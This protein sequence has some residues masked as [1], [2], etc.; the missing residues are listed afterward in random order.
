M[1]DSDEPMDLG[2]VVHHQGTLSPVCS[3]A[4]RRLPPF[5]SCTPPS[6]ASC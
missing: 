1:G 4:P 2:E 6:M 5:R 3:G